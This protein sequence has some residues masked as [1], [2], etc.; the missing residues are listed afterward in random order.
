MTAIVAEAVV[1]VIVIVDVVVGINGVV[2]E[3]RQIA[4]NYK[5]TCTVSCI[6]SGLRSC[7]SYIYI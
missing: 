7:L 5:V 2:L 4:I 1:V 6:Y 3:D